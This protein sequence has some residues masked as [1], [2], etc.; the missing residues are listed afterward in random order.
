MRI[1]FLAALALLLATSSTWAQWAQTNG[2]AGASFTG[3]AYHNGSITAAVGGG[4]FRYSI[5]NATWAR[6]STTTLM[7]IQRRQSGVWVGGGFNGTTTM[8][9]VDDG[10]TWQ[11]MAVLGT[12]VSSPRELYA[13][14]VDSVFASTDDGATWEFRGSMPWPSVTSMAADSAVILASVGFTPEL[15]RSTDGG[16]TWDT[17]TP[18][19]SA[20]SNPVTRL[21]ESGGTI[22]AVTS[23]VHATND[24]GKS[25]K[26]ICSVVPGN[27]LYWIDYDGT[28]LLA[29]TSVGTFRL[30]GNAWQRLEIPDGESPHTIDPEGN[31]IVGLF[32]GLYSIAPS[33]LIGSKLEHRATLVATSVQ[34]MGSVGSAVF[35]SAGGGIHRTTDRG[36]QWELVLPDVSAS[37]LVS[38][39]GAMFAVNQQHIYRTLDN[40]ATWLA[41]DSVFQ[42][43]NA[44]ITGVG[45]DGTWL[46]ISLGSIYS[47]H[48][49]Y[50]WESGGVYRTNNN[51]TTW[52]KASGGLPTSEVPVP[53]THMLVTEKELIINTVEGFYRSTNQGRSWQTANAGLPPRDS[54]QPAMSLLTLGSRIYLF[55]ATSPK[56][57][58]FT[59]NSEAG[60]WKQE[61][62]DIPE[63]SLPAWT[64][65][66]LVGGDNRMYMRTVV[67][68]GGVTRTATHMFDGTIWADASGILPPDV[69][70]TVLLRN[71]N[72]LYLGS[73][74][75]GVWR[76]ELQGAGVAGPRINTASRFTTA[77]NPTT[78][79]TIVEFN[80]AERA[81]ATITLVNAAGQTMAEVLNETVEPGT[82]QRV[83]STEGLP[84]GVYIARLVINGVQ[85]SRLLVKQ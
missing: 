64:V 57:M 30:V 47:E 56:P 69:S 49:S 28:T 46:Y 58:L 20:A 55:A 53:V 3:L 29:G 12:L 83:L 37:A 77:P 39:G 45:S 25:W 40:G 2:P 21:F 68:N 42:G 34:S 15:L 44:R 67:N 7:T 17:T 79:N 78:G 5:A 81:V 73:S 19:F 26:R 14:Y 33:S 23:G 60:G 35:A 31:L 6:L 16:R 18:S 61:Q 62:F 76:S 66:G 1:N 50:R 27:Y 13:N 22:F 51:G 24:Q 52:S 84:S 74:A 43:I 72:D 36:N 70:P 65:T 82:Y 80:V 54:F 59:F 32:S 48:G 11:P 85:Q 4:V 8:R 71:G 63:A 75:A 38:L 10:H 9:S 41:A